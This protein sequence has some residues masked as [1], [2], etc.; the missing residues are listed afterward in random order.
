MLYPKQ[1]F[2][3]YDELNCLLKFLEE[4]FLSLV[5]RISYEYQVLHF[6]LQSRIRADIRKCRS[7]VLIGIEFPC[8]LLH[9]KHT[10]IPLYTLHITHYTLHTTHYTLHTTHYTLHRTHY[11]LH[12]TDYTLHTTHYTLHTTHYTCDR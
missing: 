3:S 11:R 2:S 9:S 6:S 5:L 4:V 1:V 12:T 8:V 7:T 10:R